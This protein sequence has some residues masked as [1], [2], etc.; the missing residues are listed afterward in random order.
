MSNVF[1]KLEY[2][3]TVHTFLLPILNT[4]VD[5]IFVF[6][7]VGLDKLSFKNYNFFYF[8]SEYV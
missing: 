2:A 1:S 8:L 6:G 7:I 4:T 5:I 3:H